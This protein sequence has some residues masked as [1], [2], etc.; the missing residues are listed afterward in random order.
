VRHVDHQVSPDLIGNGAEL[1]ERDL[2]RVGGAEEQLARQAALQQRQP[3]LS[4]EDLDAP[5]LTLAYE[6]F[7]L[8]SAGDRVIV[9]P[10]LLQLAPGAD[11]YPFRVLVE[12]LEK[13]PAYE[14]LGGTARE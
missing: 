2:A 9:R 7:N 14:D 10:E 3:D 1:R 5:D 13:L 11:A 4:A 6:E 12:T 8:G